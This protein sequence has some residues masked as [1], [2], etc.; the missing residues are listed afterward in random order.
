MNN[1]TTT[2]KVRTETAAITTPRNVLTAAAYD[3][4]G[5]KPLAWASVRE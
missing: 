1:Q 5:D 2:A 4:S 3:P